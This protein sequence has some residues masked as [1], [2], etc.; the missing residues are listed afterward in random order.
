M[1]DV[2]AGTMRAQITVAT[3]GKEIRSHFGTS[4]F[5]SIRIIRS[6][7]VVR[8]RMIGGWMSG[9]SAMYE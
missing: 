4:K 8:S 1:S 7:F 6:F 2:A 9:T 5:A 3:I